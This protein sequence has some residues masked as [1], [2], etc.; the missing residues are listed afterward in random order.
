MTNKTIERYIQFAIKN[1]WLENLFWEY[2]EICTLDI[3]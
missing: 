1:E 3:W 2:Q